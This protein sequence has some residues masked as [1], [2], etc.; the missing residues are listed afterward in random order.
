MSNSYPFELMPLPYDYSALEPYIDTLTMQLHHDRHLKTYVTNLNNTLAN[1]P[2]YQGWSLERL[3]TEWPRLPAAISEEIRHN[4]GGVYNH[5]F[6]FNEMAGKPLS[7][8]GSLYEGITASF[9]SMDAFKKKFTDAALGVFGSGYTWLVAN[10]SGRMG[11]ITTANQDTPLIKGLKPLLC[12]DVWEHA[13]YLKHYN[14]RADYINDWL[15]L[16]SN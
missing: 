9:G 2:Q 5:Q 12:L 1:Y 14:V 16:L 8:S 4:A 15:E 3:V 7:P 13:Y 11:I 6:F 10:R